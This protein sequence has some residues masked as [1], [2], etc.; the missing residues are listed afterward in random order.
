MSLKTELDRYL[1]WLARQKAYSPAT[2]K[3]LGYDLRLFVHFASVRNVAKPSEIDRGLI[4][5]WAEDLCWRVSIRGGPIRTVTRFRHL[6]ALKGFLHFLF[7]RDLTLQDLSHVV[8]LPKLPRHLPGRIY[9]PGEVERMIHKADTGRVAG[10]RDRVILEVLYSS[11]IRASELAT[12]KICDVDHETGLIYVLE[13]KG[14]KDRVVP[15]GRI[16]CEVIRNYLL[17]ARPALV[18]GPDPGTLLLNLRGSPMKQWTIL[19][20]VK[21]SAERAK[22][23]RGAT[24]HAFRRTCATLMLR[25]GANIKAVQE[26]LGHE[27]LESTA[28]YLK[29]SARQIKEEHLKHHPREKALGQSD[30]ETPAGELAPG[31]AVPEARGREGERS[32]A[33]VPPTRPAERARVADPPGKPRRRRRKAERKK[34]AKAKHAAAGSSRLFPPSPALQGR[35]KGRVEKQRR[36]R[37][38]GGR[39]GG[40]R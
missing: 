39:P 19:E 4:E 29:V 23:D 17:S 5:E 14:K 30:G 27:S 2:V 7:E 21:A 9:K 25:D 34:K 33:E 35:G 26:I 22:L 12:L 1:F 10:L 20:V 16:A 28:L 11:G 3:G 18:Q 38:R 8:C 13:G 37:R 32:G 15:L 31:R 40:A 6:C 24:S 36:R